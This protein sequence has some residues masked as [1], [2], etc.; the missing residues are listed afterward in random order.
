MI[1]A[2]SFG[3]SSMT[4]APNAVDFREKSQRAQDG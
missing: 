3:D 4:H 2:I 1:R